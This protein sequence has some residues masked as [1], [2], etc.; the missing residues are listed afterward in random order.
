MSPAITDATSTRAAWLALVAAAALI[1]AAGW[2]ILGPFNASAAG[3]AVAAAVAAVALGCAL[4]RRVP[5]IAAARWWFADSVVERAFDGVVLGAV[6]WTSRASDPAICAAALV[7]IGG[8]F[9]ATYVRARGVALGYRLEEG[10][11]VRLLRAALLAFGLIAGALS[12]TIWVVAALSV[13]AVIV[14]SSQVMK[15]ERA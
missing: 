4:I 11:V 1:G 6:A 14:R 2:F 5:P 8:G 3:V 9:L 7:A 13:L 10:R 12:W 15:E